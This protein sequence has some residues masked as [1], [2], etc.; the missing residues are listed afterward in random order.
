ML[1][2]KVSN[3]ENL[4]RALKQLKYKVQKTGMIQ[5][6]RERQSYEKPSV[7]RRTVVKDAIYREKKYGNK[8]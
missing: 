4:D 8:G 7:S 5:E 1:F 3:G 6:L 2:V